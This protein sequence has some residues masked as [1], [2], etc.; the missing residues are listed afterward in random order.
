MSDF[1]TPFTIL[2][3]AGTPQ[4]APIFTATPLGL[5]DVQ[6]IDCVV[7]AGCAGNVGF[8]IVAGLSPAYPNTPGG[9]FVFDDYIFT[10]EVSNQLNSG[11]WGISAY[12]LDTF[13]HT[14]R[15]YFKANYITQPPPS[16]G[17]PLVSL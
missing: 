12:N 17:S 10:Q 1:T 16:V 9:F 13:P 4:S 2:V 14:L 15:F 6:E 7:P 3:P 8:Q 5:S 11:Q